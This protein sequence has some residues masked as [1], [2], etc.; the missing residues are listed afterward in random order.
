MERNVIFRRNKIGDNNME[1]KH[2]NQN[3]IDNQESILM[4]EIEQMRKTMCDR[5]EENT[6]KACV[7]E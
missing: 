5:C 6:C 2:K 3:D 4:F 7:G 1:Y